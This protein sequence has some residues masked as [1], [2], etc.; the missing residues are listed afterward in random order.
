MSTQPASFK[1]FEELVQ[2]FKTQDVPHEANAERQTIRVHTPANHLGGIIHVRW[3]KLYPFVQIIQPMIEKVPD[4]RVTAVEAAICRLNNVSMFPGL[5]Y[6]YEAHF[7]YYRIT[8]PILV[9]GLRADMFQ[10][11]LQGA[12]RNASELLAPLTAVVRDGAKGE[13]ILSH[14]KDAPGN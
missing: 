6:D 3:E 1:T 11:F 14:A 9:D 7:V 13:D 8:A 2:M 10:A 4:D 5:G 12:V